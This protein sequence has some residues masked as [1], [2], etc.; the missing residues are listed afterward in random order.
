MYFVAVSNVHLVKEIK[1]THTLQLKSSEG[2]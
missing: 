2:L 1:L